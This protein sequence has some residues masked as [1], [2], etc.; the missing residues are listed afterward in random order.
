MLQIKKGEIFQVA[1]LKEGTPV[2]RTQGNSNAQ[3]RT[4]RRPWFTEHSQCASHCGGRVFLL[5]H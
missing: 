4:M 2:Q 1:H 5:S 3:S